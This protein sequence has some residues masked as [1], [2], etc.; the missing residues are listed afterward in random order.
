MKYPQI[1]DKLFRSF[2]RYPR[3]FK[4]KYIMASL[5]NELIGTWQLLS[6]I[7]LP[8]DGG[9]SRFPMGKSPKGLLIYSPDGHMSVQIS[10]SKEMSYQSG[11]R[12]NATESEMADRMRGY[13]AFSGKY[14]VDN[15]TA[16]VVY[17]IHTSLFPNWE[18]HKQ[19]RKIDFEG[20]VLYQKSLEA[21][22]SDG[23]L[24]QSYITWKKVEKEAD[25]NFLR[26]EEHMMYIPA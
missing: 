21:I 9:D 12:M 14:T 20:D 15:T 16:S 3:K 18:K 1:C 25:E 8:I 24:V 10:A 19:F 4:T 13:I 26:D 22:L 7:E 17:S 11:D 2:L 6:Y 5:K 23:Q